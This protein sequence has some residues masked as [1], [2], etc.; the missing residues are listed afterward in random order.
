MK[1]KIGLIGL[2]NIGS[3]YAQTLIKAGY[4][5]TVFDIDEDKLKNT[6][7]QGASGAISPA[8]AAKSSD[9]V[10]LALP[11][12]EIVESV[13]LCENGIL[14]VLQA[15]QFVIDTSSCRPGTAVLL[16]R[17]CTEKKVGFLDSPLTWRKPG[18]ILMI[19]GT[20]ENFAAVEEILACISYKYRHIGPAGSGQYLKM[21]NQAVLAGLLAVYAETVELTK[22]CD[23]DPMLLREFLEFDVPDPLYTGDYSGGGNLAMHYKDLG[24]LSEI[25]HDKRASIPI[26]ALVHEIFKAAELSGEPCWIQAGIQTYYKHLNMV[27]GN[28]SGD[29]K[30]NVQ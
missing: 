4:P 9:V 20:A 11:N 27:P 26:S 14:S 1:R 29:K 23:L 24:Y 25:A 21:I 6:V 10:I 19:G 2:G 12:S 5:I 28:D 8:E 16:E 22:C 30:E 17:L 13:M 3:F 15:G 7:K 18:Q